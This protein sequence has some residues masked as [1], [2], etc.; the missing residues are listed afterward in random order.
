MIIAG[1]VV[2]LV[3]V[4][5]AISN[6]GSGSDGDKNAMEAAGVGPAAKGDGEEDPET[7]ASEPE[8]PTTERQT[9]TT[10][11][12]TTTMATTT[13]IGLGERENPIPTNLPVP[14]GDWTL[15][16]TGYEPNQNVQS[17]NQFNDP[18]PPGHTHVRVKI[19]ATYDGEGVGSPRS[20]RLNL[21][22]PSGRTVEKALVAGGSGDPQELSDQPETFKGGTLEGYL[23]F[24]VPNEDVGAQLLAFA[25]N[26]TYTDVAGGVGF[27]RVN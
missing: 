12:T 2:A 23:Y 8:T 11:A 4:I 5:A 14:V 18:P 16:V 24:A 3:A 6:G 21:V 25:P 19:S 13:T 9:T 7:V 10:V 26:V 22:T 17:F 27:F 1:A 20:I 15:T